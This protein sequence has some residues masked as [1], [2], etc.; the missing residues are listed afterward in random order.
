MANLYADD[1]Q[2]SIDQLAIDLYV[3]KDITPKQ[4]F[5]MAQAFVDLQYDTEYRSIR[6][7]SRPMY[8][9]YIVQRHTIVSG[10]HAIEINIACTD[11]KGFKVIH[12]RRRESQLPKNLEGFVEEQARNQLDELLYAEGK[13]AGVIN[14]REVNSFNGDF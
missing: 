1:K 4:A 10:N 12:I 6:T 8:V 2:H 5:D 7:I 3:N 13:R 11:I 14:T 9:R